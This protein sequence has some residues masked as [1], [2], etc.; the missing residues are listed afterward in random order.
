MKRPLPPTM[1]PKGARVV[2]DGEVAI[3]V[4]GYMACHTRPDRYLVEIDGRTGNDAIPVWD[5][6]DVRQVP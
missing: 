4:K 2:R 6:R 1:L 3:V 5:A